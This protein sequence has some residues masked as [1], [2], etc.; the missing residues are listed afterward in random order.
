[1][2]STSIKN[3]GLLHP[4]DGVPTSPSFVNV[5][6]L[7]SSVGAAF[8]TPSGCQYVRFSGTV[9][10]FVAYGSTNALFPTTNISTGA[11]NGANELNPTMRNIGSTLTTTGFSVISPSSGYVTMSWWW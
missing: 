9:D 3:S 5:A 4:T 2:S 1:M 6:V 11:G 7:G 10:F 8:D